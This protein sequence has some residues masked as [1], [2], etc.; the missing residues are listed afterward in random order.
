MFN[1]RVATSK[2]PCKAHNHIAKTSYS[3][4]SVKLF[5]LSLKLCVPRFPYSSRR[6]QQQEKQ[7]FHLDNCR[8][9]VYYAYESF[10]V[11]QGRTGVLGDIFSSSTFNSKGRFLLQ[12]NSR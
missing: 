7:W 1:E 5:D 4:L 8:Y 6:K 12:C 3:L 2:A 11:W 9:V 10:N